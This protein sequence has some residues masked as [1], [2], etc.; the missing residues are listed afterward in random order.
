MNT[1]RISISNSDKISLI[2]NFS[3]MLSAG[4]SILELVDSLLEDAKGNTKKILEV[5]R[6]D[7]MQ[8]KHLHS[9]FDKFPR[10]FDRVTVNILRA[11]EEAGTLDE[12]LLELRDNIKK[13]VEFTDKVKSALMYPGVIVCVF[14]G[15]VFMILVVVMPKISLVF[16]RLNM[17]LPLPTRI[18]IGA[19]NIILNYT[20]QLILVL[21][22]IV[23]GIVFLFIEKKRYLYNLVFSLPMLS[24]IARLIDLTQFSRSLSLLL[25]AGIPINTA[26]D[27]TEDIVMKKDISKA[28]KHCK[29]V[30]LTGRRLSEGM[31]DAKKVIPSIVIK[32]TEA[33]EKSGTLEHSMLEISQYLDYQVT[34]T[35]ATSLILLEPILM[36]VVGVMV[37]SM[38]MAIISPIYGMIGQVGAR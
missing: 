32:I 23:A 11:A 18:M 34:K 7:L 28:I 3:T 13:Q 22:I 25:S 8:G 15:V 2:S 26:L 20:L 10:V 31:K 38:M 6:E 1:E 16:G 4:I 21:G 17:E 35:L 14:V 19:S 24:D 36:V 5:V 9:S 37:G 12:T 29:D 30:V 33:G 27:L